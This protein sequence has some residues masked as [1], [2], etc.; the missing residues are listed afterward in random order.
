[1]MNNNLSNIKILLS[2]LSIKIFKLNIFFLLN[3]IHG[4]CNNGLSKFNILQIEFTLMTCMYGLYFT[5]LYTLSVLTIFAICY[6]DQFTP[7][8]KLLFNDPYAIKYISSL[9]SKFNLYTNKI[10]N[11]KYMNYATSIYTSGK[12]IYIAYQVDMY[13]MRINTSLGIIFD[14]MI[15]I[16]MNLLNKIPIIAELNNKYNELTKLTSD[17]TTNNNEKQ[18]LDDKMLKEVNKIMKQLGENIKSNINDTKTND[19]EIFEDEPNE[20]NKN[21]MDEVL[22][23]LKSSINSF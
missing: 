6:H 18:S 16:I 5:S 20:N 11:M 9:N 17:D 7:Y 14:N 12:N 8:I 23:E 4:L 13:L 1:M 19:S 10:M 2:L 3:T 22:N 15:S 21:K